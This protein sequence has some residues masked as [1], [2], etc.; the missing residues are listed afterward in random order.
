MVFAPVLAE[1]DDE[2]EPMSS[3]TGSQWEK[4]EEKT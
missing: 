2:I 1:E 3:R 4:S